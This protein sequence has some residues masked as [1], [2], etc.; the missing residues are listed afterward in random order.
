MLNKVDKKKCGETNFLKGGV[1]GP[2]AK[3]SYAKGFL[4]FC[5]SVVDVGIV[6]EI[7]DRVFGSLHWCE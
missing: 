6:T 7:L 5:L 3:K 1:L 4:S 2:F